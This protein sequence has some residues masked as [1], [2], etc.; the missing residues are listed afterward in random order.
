MAE[1]TRNSATTRAALLERIWSD[2][3]NV[4]AAE[5]GLSANG[6]AK[7]CDRLVIPRPKRNYWTLPVDKRRRLIPVLPPT[8]SGVNEVVLLAERPQPRRARTRL[9]LE[10]R[11]EQ[12]MDEAARLAVVEGV[13]EVTLKRLARDIGISEAQA[14]NCFARRLDLLIALARRE[15]AEVEKSRRGVVS[16]GTDPMTHIV[17]STVSYLNEAQAR[18]PLL[19]ALLMMPEVRRELRAERKRAQEVTRAPILA[20]MVTRY[21]ISEAEARGSNAILTAICLR[22]GGLLSTGRISYPVAERLCLPIVLAGTRSNA[23]AGRT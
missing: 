1:G 15:I 12:L 7:L 11:R 5:V 13:A 19:Q 17:L 2:P 3:L 21:G 20:S 23:R 18:G 6:L 4:V 8:P 10:D 14:H 22:A 9:S 16:R